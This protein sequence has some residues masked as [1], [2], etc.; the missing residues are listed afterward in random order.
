MSKRISSVPNPGRMDLQG[1]VR[2]ATSVGS[3]SAT[4]ISAS[5][6]TPPMLGSGSSRRRMR[7][8]SRATEPLRL[9]PIEEVAR[10]R[11]IER[12]VHSDEV[13]IS[14]LRVLADE[15]L[16]IVG[17]LGAVEAGVGGMGREDG[18]GCG[19][20]RLLFLVLAQLGG[21]HPRRDGR[22][23]ADRQLLG[24]AHALRLRAV[25]TDRGDVTVVDLTLEGVLFPL[26]LGLAGDL[27]RMALAGCFLGALMTKVAQVVLAAQTA[28]AVADGI[29]VAVGIDGGGSY[30]A[31]PQT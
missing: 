18:A 21:D 4:R 17:D 26:D 3:G 8:F 14:H 20:A 19:L 27:V 24:C 30:V 23:G 13:E 28:L 31:R 6:R 9:H 15:L 2:L 11:Q 29:F 25:E 22:C 7:A 5:I 12:R 16:D 10:R 1:D